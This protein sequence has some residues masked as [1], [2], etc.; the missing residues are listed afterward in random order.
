MP[1]LTFRV[2]LILTSLILLN[3]AYAQELSQTAPTCRQQTE[4]ATLLLEH[5]ETPP[6]SKASRKEQLAD[7]FIQTIPPDDVI[8]S[9]LDEIVR[10]APKAEQV[11]LKQRVTQHLD[12]TKIEALQ[13][14][15]LLK[16]YTEGELQQM[17]AFY[18][19][20]PNGKTLYKKSHLFTSQWV[21]ESF[22]VLLKTY[23]AERKAERLEALESIDFD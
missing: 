8:G 7:A 3:P 9:I 13:K 22:G 14:K 11:K 17:L 16:T 4:E 20:Q 10:K 6:P 1:T 19:S 2:C 23:Q 18:S 21:R 15:Y 12:K 5:A